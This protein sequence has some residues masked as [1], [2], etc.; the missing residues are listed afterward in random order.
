[1]AL[2]YRKDIDG[3][4][5]IAV[6]AVVLF[7]AFPKAIPG[8]FIG[9][10]VF[11]V[12]SGFLISTIIFQQIAEKQFRWTT[13]YIKRINRLFPALI[14]ILLCALLGGYFLLFA[15]EYQNLSKHILGST[16]FLNNFLLWKEAGYFDVTNEF[17]PLLHLWSLG[18]EEQFYLIWPLFILLLWNKKLN[19]MMAIILIVFFSFLINLLGAPHHGVAAFY[20]PLSRFWELGLGGAVAYATSF[21]AVFFQKITDINKN[22]SILLNLLSLLSLVSLVFAV[23]YFKSTF[24]Y[25]GWA[26]LLPTFCTAILLCTKTSWVNRN[27]LTKSFLTGIGIISYPLYLWHWELFSFAHIILSGTLPHALTLILLILSFCLA[28]LT[29]FFV[30]KPIRFSVK[31]KKYATLSAHIS[32]LLLLGLGGTSFMIYMSNG[33][34]SRVLAQTQKKLNADIVHFERYKTAT[35]PCEITNKEAKSLD[36]C[37]QTREGVP[38]KVIWGDSHADH[39][40]PGFLRHDPKNN[41]LLLGQSSCPPLMGTLGFWIGFKDTCAKTNEIVLETILTTPSIDTVVLASLG[42]FYISD[43]GYAMQHLKQYSP[44][45]FI[46]QS[47]INPEN[48]DKETTFYEGLELTINK[49]RAAGK[50]VV[51][52]QD[53]PEIP[54]MPERC[55]HRPLAPRSPCYINKKEVIERQKNYKALLTKLKEKYP[56]ILVFNSIDVICP[57]QSCPL[58]HKHHLVYRDSHHLSIAGSQFIGKHFM[59]WIK[60]QAS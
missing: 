4:R 45:K 31:G 11:F 20:L 36:W 9:V 34:E 35:Y 40:L 48:K 43:Q 49:L 25:P 59:D 32:A 19:P 51:L 39:L 15:D 8:G 7:H 24:I 28:W 5:A 47:K 54:F 57:Q 33:L 58:L 27:L 41:W 44:A 1:M 53:I 55:L 42:P 10:D 46:L 50:K 3:I 26:A 38:N 29:Y 16:F 13:F 56:D 60:Q 17:K 18:I 2:N 12:L 52:F 37:I 23:F 30:E 6:L 21:Y 14:I 22:Y